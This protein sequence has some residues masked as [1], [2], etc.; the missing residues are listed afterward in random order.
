MSFMKATSR[1]LL[2]LCFVSACAY[3]D[4]PVLEVGVAWDTDSALADRMLAEMQSHLSSHAPQIRLEIRPALERLEDLEAAIS[5]FEKTKRAMVIL[6]STG[7]KLLG[8]R[9]VSVPTLVGGVN[10]P[11]GLGVAEAMDK[12]KPNI[13]GVTYYIPAKRK[14]E[15]FKLVYPAMNKYLL[16]VEEGHPSSEIDRQETEADAPPLGLQGTTVYCATVE[17]GITAIEQA[18]DDVGVIIGTQP[19]MAVPNVAARLV[20][21]AGDRPVFAYSH[22]AVEGG[23]LAGLVSNDKK[24]ARMLADMLIDLLV[25]GRPIAEMPFQPDP[26]PQLRINRKALDRLRT[27]IPETIL[28]LIQDGMLLESVINTVPGGIG[29][30]EKRVF[31]QV[32]DYVVKLTGYTREELIGQSARML[33]PTQEESDYMG[34]EKYRQ[35]AERGTGT[36]ESRWLRKDG[37][38][39]HVLVSSTPLVANDLSAGVAFFVL[40]ITDR[41]EAEERFERLFDINPSIIGLTSVKDRRF[42]AINDAFTN[43][44]GYTREEVLGK[45]AADLELYVDPAELKTVGKLLEAGGRVDGFEIRL[46]KRNGEILTGLFA[47]EI[48]ELEGDRYYI[49]VITDITDRTMAQAALVRRT[50]IL[51]IGGGGFSLALLGTVC[52]LVVSLRL[53]KR[54]ARE[55]IETNKMLEAAIDRA[56]QMAHRAEV[57]NIS[58]SEFLAN[59]SHEIRTPMNAIIGFA[60][61]MEKDIPDEHH[62]HQAAIIAKSG[63]SLLRLINDILDLSKIEAGK[64]EVIHKL[65]PLPPFMEELRMMFEPS[66]KGKGLDLRFEMPPDVPEM[67]NLDEA[68][69]RQILLN[70]IGNAIKFTEAGSVVVR[71][72][73][74]KDE[75]ADRSCAPANA[76]LRISVIDTGMGVPDEAKEMIFGTFEQ[77]PGQDHAQFGGT[78]LGL[79]ISQRLARLMNGEITVSDNPA[80]KGSIFTLV[81]ENVC[82]GALRAPV[83]SNADND[84]SRVVFPSRQ[85]ILIVDDMDSNVELLRTYLLPCGFTILEAR[86]GENALEILR[87]NPVDMVLTDIKMP[88]FDGYELC[89]AIRNVAATE[90]RNIPVIAVTACTVN[91]LPEEAIAPF[92]A[93][94]IK[95]VSRNELLRAMA[96]FLPH[97]IEKNQAPPVTP[98]GQPT[99]PAERNER[100][101]A[102]IHEQFGAEIAS[103][104]KTS[105]MSHVRELGEKLTAHGRQ[106]NE[107]EIERLGRNLVAAVDACHIEQIQRILDD[108]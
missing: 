2:L 4:A 90:Q 10:N 7:A 3:G 73:M 49:A 81:L 92:D 13:S 55:L 98:P 9:G 51:F 21:A 1:A 101:S 44:L 68:R 86:D 43:V 6:R 37:A 42:F 93:V 50:R 80:G 63:K 74:R 23:A 105:R 28:N 47:S 53:R 18:G 26:T 72:D 48:I 62:R 33:Y 57:A 99:P 34:T 35:I 41:K 19:L 103:V 91:L 83:T 61:I 40:D 100:L 20:E 82:A 104:K 102:L 69:L 96:R 89:A 36:V 58:K 106:N 8:E 77:L 22:F 84:A 79:A 25:H 46:R 94:L 56:N 78:G 60:D 24:L 15:A 14:L 88:G 5:D 30:V 65:F 39:R 17:D 52:W 29:V 75:Q 95:P 32:N 31:S 11:V 16:L 38:I 27:E 85:T 87:A 71:V 107:P 97:T 54:A 70:L 67:V 76:Q 66:T 64:V 59:M 108:V 12:P 45:T